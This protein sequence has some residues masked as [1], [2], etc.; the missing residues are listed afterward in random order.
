[1]S[2][3]EGTIG[4]AAGAAAQVRLLMLMC[5]AYIINIKSQTHNQL[6]LQ[7]IAL[8]WKIQNSF[9]NKCFKNV[10]HLP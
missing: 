8:I 4:P 7:R 6:G 3:S 5:S 2:V 10:K 9:F 1:M